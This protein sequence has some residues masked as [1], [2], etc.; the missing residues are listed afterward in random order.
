[1]IRSIALSTLVLL[2]CTY[3][4]ST[5]LHAIAILGV[6]PDIGLLVLV[7]VSYRNGL[8]AGPA[9][10]FL[11][12][13]AE[14]F[15][16]ASPLGFHAFVKTAVASAAALLHG[17]FFIDRLVMPVALGIA[18]TLAKAIAAGALALLFG[19]DLHS[20]SPFERTLWIET[21]YNGVLAPIVFLLLA[22]LS[23]VLVAERARR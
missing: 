10:G 14:D 21:A 7:W 1:M 19:Q 15:L 18:G 17:S 16:S 5:W 3:V 9:A 8:V 2:G 4:Q 11:A 12:G 13:L 20:Y 22:P 6:I 23:R